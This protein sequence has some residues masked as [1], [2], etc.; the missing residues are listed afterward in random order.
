MTKIALTFD[1][2]DVEE[3]ERLSCLIRD[4]LQLLQTYGAID[5]TPTRIEFEIE[6]A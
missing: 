4:A 5:H 6:E 1:G 3:A 2:D